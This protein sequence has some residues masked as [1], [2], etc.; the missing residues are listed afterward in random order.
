MVP[1]YG[2]A[3]FEWFGLTPFYQYM[4]GIVWVWKLIS[5]HPKPNCRWLIMQC[6][7]SIALNS[8]IS[9]WG[10]RYHPLTSITMAEQI[11]YDILVGSTVPVCIIYT[12]MYIYTLYIYN[13]VYIYIYHHSYRVYISYIPS[14]ESMNAPQSMLQTA[15][16]ALARRSVHRL[17]SPLGGSPHGSSVIIHGLVNDP[18]WESWTSPSNGHYRR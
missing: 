7:P 17:G 16:R 1:L 4:Y 6:F 8:F 15:F 12:I 18:F 9:L 2:F 14:P 13:F 5:A 11:F 3:W 10:P